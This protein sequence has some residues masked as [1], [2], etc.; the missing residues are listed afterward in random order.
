MVESNALGPDLTESEIT[1][2]IKEMKINKAEGIDG[3]PGKILKKLSF[4]IEIKNKKFGM[5][6]K[7]ENN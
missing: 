7:I 1:S 3:I 4:G 6:I 2:A 5:D